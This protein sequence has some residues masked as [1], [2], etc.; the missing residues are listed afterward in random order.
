MFHP[1]QTPPIKGGAKKRSVIKR[2][3]LYILIFI[4]LLYR[5][6]LAAE[7]SVLQAE[8]VVV[9]FEEPL[10]GVAEEVANRYPSIKQDL[11]QTFQ[12]PVDFRPTLVLVKSGQQFQKIAGTDLIVA[13]AVPQKKLMVIDYSKMNTSPFTLR[14]TLKHELCHLLLHHYIDRA[15]LPKW[16]DEGICQWASD[17][18]V[19]VI[20]GS[21]RSILA[22]AGL[23]GRYFPMPALKERF[24]G[25]KASLQLAYA[26]SKSFVDYIIR[27]FG[28]DG[29]LRLLNNLRYGLDLEAAIE[30][31]FSIALEDLEKEWLDHMR[32]KNTWLTYLSIHVYEFLFVFG[33]IVIVIGFVR[34]MI[35][36]RRYRDLDDDEEED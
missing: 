23:R 31:S 24:P 7:P 19:E 17:V 8:Q 35:K 36:K 14:S 16:L 11:E 29:V 22:R 9:V 12:W 25:D 32:K 5:P 15:K 6:L 27:E 33:A 34:V 1:P 2:V 28:K 4:V 30:Q 13:F 3:S 10:R 20:M 21:D 26:Q 18:I